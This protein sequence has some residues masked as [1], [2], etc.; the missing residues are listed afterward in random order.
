MIID[1]GTRAPWHQVGSGNSARLGSAQAGEVET[2]HMLAPADRPRRTVTFRLR[3]YTATELARLIEDAGFAEVECFGDLDGW[4]LSRE[5][6]LVVRVRSTGWLERCAR[7]APCADVRTLGGDRGRLAGENRRRSEASNEQPN[8]QREF[9]DDLK[10][11]ECDKSS[12][13]V[14]PGP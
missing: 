5:S 13:G 8:T 4:Q 7:L 1:D 12:G 2:E 6:W 11:R 9:P 14:V 3:V 10:H